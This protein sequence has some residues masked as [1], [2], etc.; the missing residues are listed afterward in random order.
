MSNTR[1]SRIRIAEPLAILPAW[2]EGKDKKKYFDTEVHYLKHYYDK[3]KSPDTKVSYV[4]VPDAIGPHVEQYA[5]SD[6]AGVLYAREAEA[7]EKDSDAIIIGCFADPGMRA[8]RERCDKL[9]MSYPCAALHVASM[10]GDKFSIIITGKGHGERQLMNVI[11]EYGMESRL[12]SIRHMQ[13][14][15]TAMN[16][17]LLSRSQ[18]R[19]MER[20]ALHEATKAIE[21]DGADVIIA[22]AGCYEYLKKHLKVPVVHDSIAAIKITE[23]LVQMGLTHSKVAYPKPRTRM[24]RYLREE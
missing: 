15:P 5:E 18:R 22:Y 2:S 9:V 4:F 3:Y 24:S 21:E 11:K 23:A 6:L 8:A 17:T 10:L 19:K 14:D 13:G 16:T 12:A 20:N 1:K 7:A